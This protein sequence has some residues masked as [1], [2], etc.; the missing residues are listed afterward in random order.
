MYYKSWH[1]Q[2]R[3][4]QTLALREDPCRM[5]PNLHQ[6]A[7]AKLRGMGPN[8]NH[9][10]EEGGNGRTSDENARSPDARRIIANQRTSQTT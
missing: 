10:E 6:D 4:V 5:F 9:P 3:E 1:I 7:G 8:S 2:A